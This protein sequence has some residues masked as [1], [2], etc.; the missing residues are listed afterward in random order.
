MVNRKKV[1]LQDL[2]QELSL[3]VHTV[4]KS[5]RG[6]PGMSEE[7]RRAVLE[8]ARKKGYR[9]KE[10]ERSLAAEHIPFFSIKQRLF[11][12]IVTREMQYSL[13]YQLILQ[14]L[15]E[16]M[17]EVGHHVQTLMA[18]EETDAAICGEWMEQHRLD[19]AEGL[20][21]PPVIGRPLERK[22]LSLPVPR[23]LI[24]FP[25]PA[26]KVDSVIWDV[27]TAIWQSVRYLISNDHRRILYI[28]DT[29]THRGF[30][31][32]WR[33]FQEAMAEAGV[34][35]ES[36]RHVTGQFP[37]KESWVATVV[38]K[39]KEM[40]PTAI[41]MAVQHDLAWIYYACSLAGLTIPGDC[42]LIS[43]ENGPNKLLPGLTR[44]DLLIRETGVRA[45][46]RMLW[47]IAN[48]VQPYEHTLL[49][50]PFISGETVTACLQP[51]KRV[52]SGGGRI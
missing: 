36:D 11:K 46:E 44:P 1:T 23:I 30:G 19:Q 52:D 35:V 42:S 4:S 22:L 40:R 34:I 5:L 41:L 17:G 21:I 20:F 48:P 45:A 43:L 15:Q 50:G 27:G 47:R 28:G 37:G 10:Q 25:P 31:I 3:S 8:L 9:T 2:A 18:P 49:Q 51:A 14:G 16:K 26:E 32:R 38:A 24:N 33:A 39:V 12:L 6:L 29:V 7:T 13:M